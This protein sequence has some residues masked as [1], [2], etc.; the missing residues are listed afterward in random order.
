MS[1]YIYD[2][3]YRITYGFIKKESKDREKKNHKEQKE[4]VT[5]NQCKES[6]S[7]KVCYKLIMST[8]LFGTKWN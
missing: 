4:N 2:S 8:Y 1:T 3:I 6:V 7:V 5:P